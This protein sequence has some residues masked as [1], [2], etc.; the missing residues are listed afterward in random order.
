[1]GKL[2]RR[3]LMVALQSGSPPVPEKR[4]AQVSAIWLLFF[5]PLDEQ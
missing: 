2:L 5:H 1:M 4:V 3:R